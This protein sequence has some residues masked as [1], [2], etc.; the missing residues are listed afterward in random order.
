MLRKTTLLAALSALALTTAIPASYASDS[1]DC[2]G[3]MGCTDRHDDRGKDSN[4]DQH[5]DRGG[6]RG[7]DGHDDHGGDRGRDR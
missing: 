2:K 1:Q 6:D 3:K 4:H 5:D 7:H